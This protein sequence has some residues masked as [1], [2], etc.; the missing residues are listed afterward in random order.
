MG[1]LSSGVLWQS[2]LDGSALTA[3][4]FESALG[5]FGS[6][7]IAI[8]L[9]CFALAAIIAWAYYGQR[10]VEHLTGGSPRAVAVYRLCYV[11]ATM[12]AATLD[13]TTVWGLA[14]VLNGL[15]LLPNLIALLA[16]GPTVVRISKAYLH[17]K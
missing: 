10:A 8:S 4:A 15:M 1:L 14:D 7:V 2:G 12:W 5:Q 11:G 9:V 6:A 17:K 16:L 13:L 3:A